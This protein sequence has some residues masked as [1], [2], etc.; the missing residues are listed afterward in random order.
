MYS[1]FLGS[2]SFGPLFVQRWIFFCLLLPYYYFFFLVIHAYMY[3]LGNY[4]IYY[5]TYFLR[6][7]CICIWILCFSSFCNSRSFH[8]CWY[9]NI[10]SWRSGLL[11]FIITP[12][13]LFFYYSLI[14]ICIELLSLLETIKWYIW[15][16]SKKKLHWNLWRW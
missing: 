1:C 2:Y 15:L 12:V 6:F 9:N 8:S 14:C 4:V 16:L 5:A 13:I 3:S 10:R 7:C 11:F